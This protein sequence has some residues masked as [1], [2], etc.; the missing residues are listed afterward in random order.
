ME[1]ESAEEDDGTGESDYGEDFENG[2][3]ADWQKLKSATMLAKLGVKASVAQDRANSAHGRMK[4][5]PNSSKVN[6]AAWA[7]GQRK[8][9]PMR[10]SEMQSTKKRN[11]SAPRQQQQQQQAQCDQ[12]ALL[13]RLKAELEREK[14]ELRLPEAQVFKQRK[15]PRQQLQGRSEEE[16]L[17]ERL[18]AE[19]EREKA[20]LERQEQ[21]ARTGND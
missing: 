14:A 18:K 5:R 11:G 6:L 1:H 19:L 21:E 2:A 12:E 3:H 8:D 4:S 15:S 10:S 9:L 20:E 7:S 17:L 13:E 16:A